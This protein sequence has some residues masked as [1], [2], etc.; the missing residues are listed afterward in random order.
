MGSAAYRSAYLV[1]LTRVVRR[2]LEER[3]P[4][5]RFE[6][7]PR[8]TALWTRLDVRWRDGPTRVLV[9]N[10][11]E[12]TAAA[13]D[14]PADIP[15][16]EVVTRRTLTEEGVAA[17]LGIA[18]AEPPATWVLP[19]GLVS[20]VQFS[21]TEAHVVQREFLLPERP[22]SAHHLAALVANRVDLSF[23]VANRQPYRLGRR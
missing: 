1:R 16:V 18:T 8:P 21:I 19:N 13:V 3:G 17:A 5:V 12:A 14:D 20:W 7:T 6:V 2:V 23:A 15:A 11:V 10:L 22:V 9:R 4:T